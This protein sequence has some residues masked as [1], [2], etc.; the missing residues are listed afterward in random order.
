MG[1]T[2]RRYFLREVA[3]PFLLG[4]G[5]FTFI[6]LIARMLKLVELVVNR[7][8]PCSRSQALRLHPADFLEV[9]VPMALLLAVC[10]RFGARPPTARSSRSRPRASASIRCRARSAFHAVVTCWRL[11]LAVYA[12]PWGNST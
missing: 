12:R 9:T 1:P 11:L 10:C 7:S 3:V 4:I 8:V 2:L 5:V 6:L